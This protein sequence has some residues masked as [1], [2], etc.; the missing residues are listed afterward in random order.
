MTPLGEKLSE[1]RSMQVTKGSKILS[2]YGYYRY[3]DLFSQLKTFRQ[4]IYYHDQVT[5]A[6]LLGIHPPSDLDLGTVENTG[7]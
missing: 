4:H 1:V 5:F 6:G 2:F 3:A 7:L